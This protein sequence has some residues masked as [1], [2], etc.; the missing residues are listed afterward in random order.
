[1]HVHVI[2]RD[3]TS[4]LLERSGMV[5]VLVTDDDGIEVRDALLGKFAQEHISLLACIH[6]DA[7]R[8]ALDKDAI[9][10]P[11]V[12]H[13]HACIR[14]LPWSCRLPKTQKENERDGHHEGGACLEKL[15][16]R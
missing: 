11:H 4:E 2:D 3:D 15:V 7:G 16:A 6:E 1:M 9:A 10:L 14:R 8:L 13:H 5:G 12:E